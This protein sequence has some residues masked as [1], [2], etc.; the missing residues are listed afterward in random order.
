MYNMFVNMY[1]ML[2]F[3]PRSRYGQNL[4]L[5]YT[6]LSQMGELVQIDILIYCYDL[7]TNKH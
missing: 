5:F 2:E 3:N 4:F 7:T 1:G 6:S